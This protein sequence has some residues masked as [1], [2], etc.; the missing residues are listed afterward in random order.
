MIKRCFILATLLVLPVVAT[1]QLRSYNTTLYDTLNPGIQG[2]PW[3]YSSL[4][5][6][7]AGG[8]EYALLGSYTGT[9]II[10]VTE[11]P[12]REVAFIEGP[13]SGWRE[14]KTAGHYAY[15]VTEGG[16]GLQIID[17]SSL[18]ASAAA[19]KIDSRYFGSAHTIDYDGRYLYINGTKA[20]A[21][22]NGGTMILDLSTG[23]TTPTLVGKWDGRYVHDVGIR[24]DTLYAAAINDGA[25][26]IV[27]LGKDRKSPVKVGEIAYPGGGTHNA[28]MTSDG[29]YILT[30][31]EISWTPKTLK[32]WDRSNMND[33]RKVAD[34]SPTPA[35]IIHNVHVRGNLAYIAWYTGGTRIIDISDPT[36]PA[37]IAYY[38]EYRDASGGYRGNWEVYPDL[39]SGKILMSDM[40]NGLYVFTFTNP[41]RGSASGV[42]R[43]SKTGVPIPGAV[44]TFPE[45]QRSIVAD[46]N[47]A[48]S[49]DGA[50]DTLAFT[51]V[52]TG[53]SALSGRIILSSTHPNQDLRLLPMEDFSIAAIDDAGGGALPSF[54]YVIADRPAGDGAPATANPQDL[55]LSTDS[56]Y[57]L[58]VGAWGYVPQLVTVDGAGERN[59]QVRLKHGYGDDAE[60]D[61]GW[62]FSAPGDDTSGTWVRGIPMRATMST[63]KGKMVVQPD[64]DRTPG[65]GHHAFMTGL[66]RSTEVTQG[67][68]N[69]TATLTS[70]RFDLSGYSEPSLHFSLWFANIQPLQVD[71]DDTLVVQL[72][73]N[74]GETWTTLLRV[75]SSSD[76]WRDYSIKVRSVLSLSANMRMRVVASDVGAGSFVRAG[77]DDFAVVE[78]GSLAVEM[79]TMAER[80]SGAIVPNPFS[81]TAALH[82]ELATPQPEL[83]VELIDALGREVGTIRGGAAP[84][85]AV[86]LPIERGQLSDG[87]YF[88]RI[89]LADASQLAGTV[90]VQ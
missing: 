40:Q 85:G 48:W 32:I 74:G 47:G 25:L 26:D 34:Y 28:D 71:G 70:P 42:V 76:A 44:I 19:V 3:N 50:I 12:I 65:P 51:A 53:Y 30:T 24:N 60:L 35:D 11:R 13:H 66:L 8:R 16:G 33:I 87:V 54:S 41:G 78:G 14:M 68:V 56:V 81:S 83:R 63:I 75:D 20:E 90:V 10:D 69:G 1:A 17:L 4:T 23:A 79:T 88:W 5:G 31:D 38:D 22:A 52:A 57:T 73:N 77:L 46:A 89:T 39:P 61:L 15:V 45:Q 2:A 9:H 62:S 80:S 27:Y 58:E 86:V 29:R 37:E 59:V 21:G 18:P 55:L 43:N 64:S 49:L 6:Y 36:R 67:D 82:L 84:A 72:S 7:A